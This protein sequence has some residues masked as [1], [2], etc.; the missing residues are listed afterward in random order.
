ME[1]WTSALTY[2]S[3]WHLNDGESAAM[4]SLYG[5]TQGVAIQTKV[6]RLIASFDE[7][8]TVVA[9]EYCPEPP[10]ASLGNLKVWKR[11]SFAH[12]REIRLIRFGELPDDPSNFPPALLQ[13]VTD[14]VP[15]PVD[16]RRLIEHV[17]VS[18]R[19]HPWVADVIRTA[20]RKHGFEDI[21]VQRSPLYDARA[22]S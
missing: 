20:V 8:V 22:V 19:E 16:V 14:G 4:W 6:S 17:Y 15:V 2:A 18:P 9:V 12:E 3:C 10:Y 7:D 21:P 11:T 13:N 5:H 1:N